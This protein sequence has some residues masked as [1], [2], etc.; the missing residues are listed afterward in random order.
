MYYHYDAM[1]TGLVLLAWGVGESIISNLGI[2][3]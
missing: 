1:K 2:F 3:A